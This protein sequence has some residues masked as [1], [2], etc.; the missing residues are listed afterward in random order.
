MLELKF[1]A[2]KIGAKLDADAKRLIGNIDD[3]LSAGAIDIASQAK[4]NASS[5]AHDMGG[6]ASSINSDTKKK[7]EKFVTVGV[8]YAAYVEF[9]TGKYAA[10]YVSALPPDWKTYAARFKGK[11]AA[12]GSFEEFLINIIEWV[13]RKGLAGTYSV[14]TKRRTG[15]KGA[16]LFE[17]AAVAYPI[18][19]AIIRNGIHP[20]P[21]LYPAF[22]QYRKQI[23]DDIKKQIAT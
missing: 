3:I 20:H 12:G 10:A 19:L 2:I 8:F 13:K 7:L 11:N 23:I 15:N 6:L 4:I 16:R 22:E 17:D 21:F 18:A 1:D 5:V 9:G 14:K